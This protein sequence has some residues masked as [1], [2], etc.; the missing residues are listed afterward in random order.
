MV[1]G[2]VLILQVSVFDVCPLQAPPWAS[3]TVF[4]LDFVLTPSLQLSQLL[5]PPQWQSTKKM[6][7]SYVCIILYNLAIKPIKYD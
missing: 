1:Q 2:Y 4:V 6:Q 7:I 3:L 5:H